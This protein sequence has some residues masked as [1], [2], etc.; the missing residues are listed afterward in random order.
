[1]KKI[2]IY[3]TKKKKKKKAIWSWTIQKSLR[4][5]KRKACWVQKKNIIQWEKS[6]DLEMLKVYIGRAKK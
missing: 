5:W 6:D 4:G 2:K 3:L 1:M